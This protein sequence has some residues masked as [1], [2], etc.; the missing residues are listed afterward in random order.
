MT[1]KISQTKLLPGDCIMVKGTSFF[2]KAIILLTSLHTKKALYSHTACYIGN[3]HCIEALNRTKIT[4]IT[5]LDNP[6]LKLKVYR[7]PM[8]PVQRSEF[9]YE[10]YKIV[11]RSYGWGKIPL[12]A[13]DAIA[14]SIFT[15]FGRETP[16]FFFTKYLG[17]FNIPVCSQLYVYI[18]GKAGY[19]LFNMRFRTVPWRIVS[20]DYLDDILNYPMNHSEVIF[21]QNPE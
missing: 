10:S 16:V 21:E 6:K 7:L 18:L 14:T 1:K 15:F 11:N 17:I 13:A 3:G 8:S 9:I 4:K 19:S 20:P 2:S 12:F 5:R